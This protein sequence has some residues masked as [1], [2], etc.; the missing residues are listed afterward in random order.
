MGNFCEGNEKNDLML[1]K[2]LRFIK[3]LSINNEYNVNRSYKHIMRIKKNDYKNTGI[4]RTNEYISI[5]PKNKLIQFRS[6][7]WE[8][9]ISGN[10]KV[11][12]ILK[13]I[14]ENKNLEKSLKILKK[15]KIFLVGNSLQIC[16]DKMGKRYVIPIFIINDPLEYNV[17]IEKKKLDI[18]NKKIQIKAKILESEFNFETELVK[19][20]KEVRKQIERYLKKI[21][22]VDLEKQ[23]LRVLFRGKILKDDFRI[24]DYVSE[25][26]LFQ[27][28]LQNK[29]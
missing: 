15:N 9:R 22:K 1:K 25:D 8:S 4:F 6:E 24:G 21:G 3:L 13:Q 23:V 5:I 28:F 20:V 17:K 12:S 27:I 2:D 26:C 19:T 11:W 10:K 14:I 18:K 29:K 7:F 16:L